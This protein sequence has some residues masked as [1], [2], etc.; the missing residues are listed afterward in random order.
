[1]DSYKDNVSYKKRLLLYR[2]E[3][4]LGLQRDLCRWRDT[5]QYSPPHLLVYTKIDGFYIYYIFMH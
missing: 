4:G 3:D 1:M 2:E 5:K